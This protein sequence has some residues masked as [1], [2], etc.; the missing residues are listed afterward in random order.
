M[1]PASRVVPT[2]LDSRNQKAEATAVSVKAGQR[3]PR[4]RSDRASASLALSG[5]WST[6]DLSVCI[7]WLLSLAQS[8]WKPRDGLTPERRFFVGNAQWACEN[9]QAE[10]LRM[11]AITNPHSPGKYRV[12]GL[13]VNMPEFEKAFSCKAGRW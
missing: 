4:T 2:F 5:E 3:P 7:G 6:L 12:N 10:D 9:D 8:A 1:R 13:V 11:N